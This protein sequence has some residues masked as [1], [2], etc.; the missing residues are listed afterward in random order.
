MQICR[1]IAE[2]LY[3]CIKNFLLFLFAIYKKN[4][5]PAKKC[6]KNKFNK[7]FNN[8]IKGY[9]KDIRYIVDY[10]NKGENHTK[11]LLILI[12]KMSLLLIEMNYLLEY[13]HIQVT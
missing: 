11:N 8:P 2:Y 6:F 3:F 1:F 9:S 4:V 5:N 12:L 13:C 10:I 7:L